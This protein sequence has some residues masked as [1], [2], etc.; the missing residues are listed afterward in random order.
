MNNDGQ[1]A[2]FF[3]HQK[4]ENGISCSPIFCQTCRLVLLAQEKHLAN[5]LNMRAGCHCPQTH[6]ESLLFFFARISVNS[7]VV[8]GS[9]YFFSMWSSLTWLKSRINV[10][11]DNV[12]IWRLLSCSEQVLS[13]CSTVTI[14]GDDS[15]K[16]KLHDNTWVERTATN[17]KNAHLSRSLR[18]AAEAAVRP[19]LGVGVGNSTVNSQPRKK[20][21]LGADMIPVFR[22]Q[23]F[24]S[25]YAVALHRKSPYRFDKWTF[26]PVCGSG[27]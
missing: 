16:A 1:F 19:G 8:V 5:V 11:N 12:P 22:K 9:S 13:L 4:W 27:L 3:P 25:S 21:S 20:R 7:T 23:T 15:Q 26:C 2:L 10:R 14:T 24:W 17:S 6:F 18:S